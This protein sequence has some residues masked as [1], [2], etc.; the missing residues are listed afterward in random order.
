VW[1]ASLAEIAGHV[2]SLGLTPRELPPPEP[3]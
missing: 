1:V 2:R 3:W